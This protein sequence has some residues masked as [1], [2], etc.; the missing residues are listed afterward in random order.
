MQ[1]DIGNFSYSYDTGN[2][3]TSLTNHKSESFGFSYDTG[4]RLTGV[5]R[6]GS[7]TAFNFDD[8]NFLTS[9]IHQKTSGTNINTFSYTKDLIG[10]RK[11]ASSSAGTANYDYDDNNQLTQGTN[12]ESL[13]ENFTYDSN[14]NR[15]TDDFGSYNYDAN[16]QR[17]TED[18]RYLY[19]YDENGNLSSKN[20]KTD[21][22]VI[23]YVHN[24]ENQLVGIDYFEGATPTK[25]ITYVYD[26]LGRRVKK[27]VTD[28][29]TPANSFTR[30]YVYD[31]NEI[32]AEFDIDNKL[33][34]TYTHSTLRTDDVLS[35]DVTTDGVAK[36]TAQAAQSYFYI[37]DGQGTIVDI[38][39]GAGSKVQHHIYSAFGELVN[40]TDASGNVIS[41]N[42]VLAPFFTYTNREYDKESGLYHY[43][44]RNYDASIGRF[45]EEDPFRGELDRPVTIN[46]KYV[47]VLNK[48][49][50][51][52]DPSGK[53]LEA[54]V[55]GA[56]VGAIVGG[57]V[58]TIEDPGNLD[59]AFEGILEGAIVG[60]IYGGLA[61]ASPTATFLS[62]GLAVF[63]GFL[64]RGNVAVNIKNNLTQ[65][66]SLRVG[67]HGSVSFGE[68]LFGKDSPFLGGASIFLGIVF[69]YKD[70]QDTSCNRET[71]TKFARDNICSKN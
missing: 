1:T 59:H 54:L 9:I 56:I 35:V 48:P 13:T 4:N 52:V 38:V 46:N 53:F 50:G 28:L 49:T 44:A 6:P 40:T 64:T 8:T 26:A 15:L 20:S 30:K 5:S 3:L 25:E 65:S 14:G 2:R 42:E 10:N 68:Y 17:L 29:V 66:T 23:N 71:A 22:K 70:I 63:T 34:A 69:A 33:L 18:Y 24:S 36:G 37:K 32:L 16:S 45:L 47:Y 39:D 55:V 21:S 67:A 51:F 58:A 7:D 41:G 62:I 61:F 19:F 27:Q 12:P 11:T 43:R 60:A 57:I 31:G